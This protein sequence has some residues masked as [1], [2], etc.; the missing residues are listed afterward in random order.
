MDGETPSDVDTSQ[1]PDEPLEHAFERAQ[2]GF[3]VV[4]EL[5]TV[6]R[7]NPAGAG[8]LG[9]TPPGICGSDLTTLVHPDDLTR[10]FSEL[11]PRVGR[12]GAGPLPHRTL[13]APPA[14][15]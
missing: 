9:T 15:G 4:D 3:L 1:L 12:G 14:W 11:P 8:L 5:G 10:V 6:L 7:A 2:I 13:P